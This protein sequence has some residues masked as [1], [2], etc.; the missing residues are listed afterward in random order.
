[1]MISV[2]LRPFLVSA[3]GLVVASCSVYPLHPGVD[4]STHERCR[5]E[6]DKA[7]DVNLR[8][9]TD[10]AAWATTYAVKAYEA[11]MASSSSR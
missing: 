7:F 11:C 8:G 5:Q 1:M 3:A 10:T 6:G 2:L 4:A 9:D